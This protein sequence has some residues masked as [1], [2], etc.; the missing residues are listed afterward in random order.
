MST[1]K[2]QEESKG[3]KERIKISS[4][5]HWSPCAA[6]GR[7]HSPKSW[8]GETWTRA[9]ALMSKTFSS[10][11]RCGL[12][13]TLTTNLAVWMSAVT[14]ESVHKAHSKLKKN[15]TE[16]IFRWLLKG[17]LPL[18]EAIWSRE[19]SHQVEIVPQQV[20]FYPFSEGLFRAGGTFVRAGLL[21][22]KN[23]CSFPNL[24]QRGV[25]EEEDSVQMRWD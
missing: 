9:T 16:E 17:N 13:L 14:D 15:M 4:L 7:C 2:K 5:G 10:S 23:G 19:R 1:D 20:R 22:P 18:C 12:M 24:C 21:K 8:M 3:S 11:C 6:S 25:R